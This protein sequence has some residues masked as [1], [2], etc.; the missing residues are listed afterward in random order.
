MEISVTFEV[1][2]NAISK[3]INKTI[4]TTQAA[5]YSPKNCKKSCLAGV[6]EFS[7]SEILLHKRQY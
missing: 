5:K 2:V 6:L 4:E 3:G 1:H 7:D